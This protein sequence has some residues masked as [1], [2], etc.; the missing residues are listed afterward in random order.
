MTVPATDDMKT[1]LVVAL[2]LA[3]AQADVV[4]RAVYVEPNPRHTAAE[5]EQIYKNQEYSPEF[6]PDY[7]PGTEPQPGETVL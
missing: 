2:W 3:T 4:P 1:L 6:Y 5:W 7:I